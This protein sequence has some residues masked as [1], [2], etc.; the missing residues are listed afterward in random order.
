MYD[1]VKI[2]RTLSGRKKESF[3]TLP[4]S[5]IL[6]L[7]TTGF[8]GM[9]H[10]SC[11]YFLSAPRLSMIVAIISESERSSQRPETGVHGT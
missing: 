5:L 3:E 2:F 9:Y 7:C 6:L 4:L 8:T 10:A 11:V 1:A